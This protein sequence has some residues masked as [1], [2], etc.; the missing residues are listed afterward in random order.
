[1]GAGPRRAAGLWRAAWAAGAVGGGAGGGTVI[2][3]TQ[4][5]D[6]THKP[7]KHGIQY[8]VRRDRLFAYSHFVNSGLI[9]R[10]IKTISSLAGSSRSSSM[11]LS[12][13][14]SSPIIAWSKHRENNRRLRF[15]SRGGAISKPDPFQSLFFALSTA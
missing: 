7:Q 14:R 3:A 12:A 4:G 8:Q 15:V 13:T 5:S 11:I 2:R 6:E 10:P 1:M 9:L